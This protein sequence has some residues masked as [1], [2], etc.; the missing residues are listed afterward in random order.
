VMTLRYSRRSFRIVI[1]KS[2]S[3]TWARLHEEAFRYFGGSCT[4]VVLAPRGGAPV[5]SLAP[6]AADSFAGKRHRTPHGGTVPGTFRAA[7]TASAT[8]NVGHGGLTCA[9]SPGDP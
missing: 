5:Q 7:G 2:S 6:D 4:Y 1:W 3:E 9:L 8:P